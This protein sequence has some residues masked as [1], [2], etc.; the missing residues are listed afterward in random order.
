MRADDVE[1]VDALLRAGAKVRRPSRL[2][3]TPIYVAAENGNAAMLRRLLDA[4][5]DVNGTDA[6][7]DTL[8]MAAVRAG[9]RR[10]GRTLLDGGAQVNAA[11]P[12]VGH[13][14][15]MWAVR[16]EQSRRS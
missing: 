4:G 10:C 14:A 3:V 2:G 12:E 16:E 11:E 15:L 7:G 5:A 8:L 1:T 9:K 13:T 6:T